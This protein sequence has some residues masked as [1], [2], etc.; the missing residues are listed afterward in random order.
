MTITP[1][2]IYWITRL[3]QIVYIATS[4]A[5]IAVAGII[6]TIVISFVTMGYKEYTNLAY[7]VRK[8]LIITLLISMAIMGFVPTKKEVAAIITIPTIANS[9]IVQT[10]TEELT[11]LAIEW[12]REQR[13]ETQNK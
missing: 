9:K 5:S 11:N 8:I 2:L 1:S 6:I 12:L 3:D 13:K 4:I 10:G 7:K